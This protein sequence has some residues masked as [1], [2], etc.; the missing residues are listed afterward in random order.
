MARDMQRFAAENLAQERGRGR[1]PEE[2]ANDSEERENSHDKTLADSFPTSDPPS[3]IPDPRPDQAP[4]E[5]TVSSITDELIQGLTPGSWA[6]ISIDER[7][8]VGKGATRDQAAEEAQ[9]AGH[10]KISLIQVAADP[11][12]PGGTFDVAS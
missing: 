11:E 12:A 3:T 8:V 7:R 10:S 6:A 4:P 1:D 5:I 2:R 9:R